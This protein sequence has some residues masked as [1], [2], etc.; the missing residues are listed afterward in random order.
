MLVLLLLAVGLERFLVHGSAAASSSKSSQ[1]GDCEEISIPMCR[2]IGYNYTSMPNQ[3]LHDTQ[4]EAGLEGKWYHFCVRSLPDG[5]IVFASI[6]HDH[7]IKLT[8]KLAHGSK[9]A[10]F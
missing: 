6:M 1:H 4:D 2:G 9:L 3:F 5:W 7:R 8:G 10:T